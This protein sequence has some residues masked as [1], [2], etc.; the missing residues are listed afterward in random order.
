MNVSAFIVNKG[1]HE[2]AVR[3]LSS[4]HLECQPKNSLVAGGDSVPIELSFTPQEVGEFKSKVVVEQ[5]GGKICSLPVTAEAVMPQV[6]IVEKEFDFGVVYYGANRKL[7]MTLVNSGPVQAQVVFDL[8]KHAMFSLILSADQWDSSE[9]PQS[10]LQVKES[11]SAGSS[12][13]TAAAGCIPP[14]FLATGVV[15]NLSAMGSQRP[16]ELPRQW[17]TCFA[18]QIRPPADQFTM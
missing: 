1:L 10:P 11:T 18:G 3:V 16:K 17:W 2:S 13:D 8:T 7:T 6:S 14:H 4:H 12:G 9:Y 15:A 5:R